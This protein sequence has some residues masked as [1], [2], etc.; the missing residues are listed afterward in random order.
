MTSFASAIYV[1]TLLFGDVFEPNALEVISQVTE[2]EVWFVIKH[3]FSAIILFIEMDCDLCVAH[4]GY[5]S[6]VTAIP[7]AYHLIDAA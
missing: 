3:L 2:T 7:A 5:K 4:Y 6:N 1:P